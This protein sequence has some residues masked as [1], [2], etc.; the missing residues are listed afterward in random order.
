MLQPEE[1]GTEGV[2]GAYGQVLGPYAQKRAQTLFHFPRGLV[3]EGNRQ[4]V[5]GRNAQA[6]N[7]VGNA[8]GQHARLTR[9]GSGPHEHR[10]GGRG[11]G[12]PLLG[13]EFVQ[14]VVQR[15]GRFVH[16]RSLSWVG[17]M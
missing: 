17:D 1:A 8:V 14:K 2:E 5:P 11:H 15:F 6:Q 16:G 7:Q 12:L 4:D 9:T 13:V 3:G 10:A